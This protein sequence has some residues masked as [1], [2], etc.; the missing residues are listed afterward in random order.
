M[1]NA[2]VHRRLRYVDTT[3]DRSLQL[4]HLYRLLTPKL[5]CGLFAFPKQ[6]GNTP[7]HPRAE[8]NSLSTGAKA[9]IGVGVSVG[10]IAMAAAVVLP[11]HRKRTVGKPHVT[12]AEV[13]K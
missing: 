1:G 13:V 10:V 4:S 8:D 11:W 12:A 6:S 2:R 3:G 7:C 5:T 9:G